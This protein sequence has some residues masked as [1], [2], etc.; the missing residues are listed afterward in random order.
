MR[1]TPENIEQVISELTC[2]SA[3]AIDTETTG[4]EETDVPFGVSIS[5]GVNSY[6]FR[7]AVVP[8]MWDAINMLNPFTWVLQNAK[9]DLKML[10]RKGVFLA[11]NLLDITSEARLVR[12]DHLQYNLDSQAKRELKLAK[13][14]A[15][16]K[17]IKEHKL[18][19]MRKD[20][21]GEEYKCPRYDLVPDSIMAEYA[22]TDALLTYKLY[23]HY[24]STMS[25]TCE[26]VSKQESELIRVCH[27]MERRGLLIN[28]DYTLRAFY[29]ESGLRDQY[30]E[31]YETWTGS[32]FVNSAK[33]VQKHLDIKLPLTED[34]NPSLT[35]DI[36][37]SLLDVTSPQDKKIIET[38]RL[39]RNYDKRISTYYKSYLNLMDSGNVIHPSM[40][41]SGTRTGRFSYSDPNFQNMPKEEDST[42]EFV[43][44]GCIMPRPGRVFVSFDYKQMEYNLAVAYANQTDVIEKVMA[45]A[46]FHQATADL[47]GITRSQ[48]KTLNFAVL[49]GAG[50]DKI[51]SMLKCSVEAA[52]RLKLKYFMG[53]PKVENLIDSIIRTG[54][55]RG[56][57]VNWMGRRLFAFKEFCYAL[58]NHLIQSGGADIVKKAMVTIDKELP[59]LMMTLQV[60]DQLIF[61]MTE[62]EYVHIERI[63]QIMEDAFPAMNGIKLRVDIKWS[64]ASLAER[65]MQDYETIG[66]T[67]KR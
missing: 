50:V 34:G 1:V 16:E 22:I 9:F 55:S 31:E 44:R 42:D 18:Y 40:W 62:D 10:E 45:G 15:V 12:N 58:P 39:I 14:T 64:A 52:T 30:L 7:E 41:I 59:E 25:V 56:H 63:K 60:H 67:C 47:V 49:Y 61:E 19:E 51:A 65:D 23:Q 21:F 54:R 28:K 11:G 5:D 3:L 8:V 33:S 13:D 53:L 38:V 46:D 4:L 37:E 17:Y 27:R 43:V 29:H 66:V 26:H 6:W 35:D 57:V 32:K 48:A 24:K 36:I 20:F 2:R